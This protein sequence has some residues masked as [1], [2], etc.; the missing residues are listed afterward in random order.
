MAEQIEVL[1]AKIS[2]GQDY[3]SKQF[4]EFKEEIKQQIKQIEIKESQNRD[5]IKDMKSDIRYFKDTT[6]DNYTNIKQL[7]EERT[8]NIMQLQKN[9]MPNAMKY[10]I[11]VIIAITVIGMFVTF[12]QGFSQ[13]QD[14]SNQISQ[15]QSQGGGNK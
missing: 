4:E 12:N 14:L 3:L 13:L 15:S 5:E 10:G 7:Q 6:R 2:T 9:V 1:L 11:V 8:V